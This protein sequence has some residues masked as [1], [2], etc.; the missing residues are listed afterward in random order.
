MPD[1]D[2]D[3]DLVVN[4]LRYA[5]RHAVILLVAVFVLG[6]VAGWA[7]TLWPRS[8]FRSVVMMLSAIIP[9]LWFIWAYYRTAGL[10]H[11]SGFR[12]SRDVE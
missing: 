6:G 7:I 12:R 1:T 9:S 4:H 5:V 8:H 2:E 11:H 10:L 3:I